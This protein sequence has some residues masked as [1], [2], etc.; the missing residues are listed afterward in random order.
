MDVVLDRL[1]D[2]CPALFQPPRP[3]TEH[4]N[5]LWLR[6]YPSTDLTAWVGNG[7]VKF[8]DPTRG[9]HHDIVVGREE[10]W[11][12]ASVALECGRRHGIYYATVALPGQ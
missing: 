12:K 3:Q 6:I 11:A 4:V 8:V 2:A 9:G 5:Q 1:E 10:E 7:E